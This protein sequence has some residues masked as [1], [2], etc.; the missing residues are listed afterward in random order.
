MTKPSASKFNPYN[1]ARGQ[2]WSDDFAPS[3]SWL[4]PTTM[5]WPD[6]KGAAHLS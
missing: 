6:T 5:S 4:L 3:G 1:V 2:V